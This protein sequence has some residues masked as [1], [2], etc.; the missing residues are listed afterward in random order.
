MRTLIYLFARLRCGSFFTAKNKYW[1]SSCMN[2]TMTELRNRYRNTPDKLIH[3]S[4]LID[5]N[6]KSL[7]SSIFDVLKKHGL[8]KMI[9]ARKTGTVLHEI[10]LYKRMIRGMKTRIVYQ[11]VEHQIATIQFQFAAEAD[12]H[13]AQLRNYM[14]ELAKGTDLP[15]EGSFSLVD[16][17]GNRLDY[18]EGF[19]VTLTFVNHDPDLIQNINSAVY[20]NR[21][22][23]SKIE[24]QRRLELSL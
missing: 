4:K 21:F 13:F 5:S 15:T 22:Q 6:S 17:N 3:A 9:Q 11:F 19:K 14:Q 24:T 16:S 12:I 7:N 23:P 2:E 18:N 8:P 20:Q 1:E 10:M